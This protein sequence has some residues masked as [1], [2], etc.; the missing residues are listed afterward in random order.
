MSADA[1]REM[2]AREMVIRRLIRQIRRGDDATLAI[3]DAAMPTKSVT[4][5]PRDTE[6]ERTCA[7]ATAQRR[8][9]ARRHARRCA[10]YA[11][12][13]EWR[14]LMIAICRLFYAGYRY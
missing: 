2:V 9:A 10:T 6:G 11:I 7:D 14:L 12:S 13:D 1:E 3:Y 5:P 4:M 8:D